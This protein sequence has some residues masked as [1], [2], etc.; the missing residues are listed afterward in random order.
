MN[1]YDGEQLKVFNE[2]LQKCFSTPSRSSIDR[3]IDRS[4]RSVKGV[5]GARCRSHQVS[6]GDSVP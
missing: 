3:S 1:I 2:L 6:P 5:A 4:I